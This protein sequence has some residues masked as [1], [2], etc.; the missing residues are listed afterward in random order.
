MNRVIVAEISKNW[1]I[2][3]ARQTTIL[4][5]DFERVINANERRG[6]SLK[7]W[8]LSTVCHNGTINETIVAIFERLEK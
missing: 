8:K 5:Q 6:Y 7:D 2:D 4:S 1:T 3:R